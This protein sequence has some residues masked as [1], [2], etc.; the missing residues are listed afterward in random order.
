M[1]TDLKHTVQSPFTFK[2]R[3]FPGLKFHNPVER[4][5]ISFKDY[6]Y[7]VEIRNTNIRGHS[8]TFSEQTFWREFY[9]QLILPLAF[10]INLLYFFLFPSFLKLEHFQI[11]MSHLADEK[12]APITF[13]E[14]VFILHA[15][16]FFSR[17]DIPTARRL[18]KLQFK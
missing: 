15:H 7:L 8:K 14:W 12:N 17:G 9:W 5:L 1:V 10:Q 3:T 18:L 2:P 11:T 4:L 13:W 6:L 16:Q